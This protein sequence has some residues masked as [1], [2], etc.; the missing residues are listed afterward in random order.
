MD[1]NTKLTFGYESFLA[2]LEFYRGLSSGLS[3]GQ[4]IS[5]AQLHIQKT[6]LG[7]SARTL[8]EFLEKSFSKRFQNYEHGGQSKQTVNK[9]V[10]RAM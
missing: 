5:D 1:G 9:F 7:F 2:D 10:I 4:K 8:R 3:S 6:G